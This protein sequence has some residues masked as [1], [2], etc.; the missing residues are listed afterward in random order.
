MQALVKFII[1]IIMAS[2][3]VSSAGLDSLDRFL[4]WL[5]DFIL[6]SI[7]LAILFALISIPFWFTYYGNMERVFRDTGPLPY[8]ISYS[9]S[10]LLFCSHS[11]YPPKI[12]RDKVSVL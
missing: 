5:V 8:I 9:I 4:A 2:L 1:F 11:L 12:F 10:Y 3:F 6:V 7:G